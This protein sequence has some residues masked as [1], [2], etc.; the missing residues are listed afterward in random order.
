[1]EHQSVTIDTCV[2]NKYIDNRT[3]KSEIQALLN[4]C[5]D[6]GIKIYASSR[7]FSFDTT[8][9]NPEQTQQIKELMQSIG[10]QVTPAPFILG[11][12]DDPKN[13]GS[14]FGG[15]DF[16]ADF[17]SGKRERAFIAEVGCH[18]TKNH[19]SQLGK[20]ASNHIG[21][22]DALLQHYMNNFDVFVTYD[23]HLYLAP[24]KRANYKKNLG[25]SV[26]NPAEFLSSLGAGI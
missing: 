16:L 12:V 7:V 19:P 3:E 25:L 6:Q 21:D 14:S 9:Q 10:A 22:Y 15:T 8:T 5:K 20:K 17:H 4:A 11:D 24:A 26:M 18:P 23:T 1:M 2:W 13:T